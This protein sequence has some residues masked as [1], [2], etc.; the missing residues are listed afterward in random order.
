MMLYEAPLMQ[1]KTAVNTMMGHLAGKYGMP[2][3]L[4]PVPRSAQ[5]RGQTSVPLLA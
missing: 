2:I 1:E 3:I 4:T 5:L